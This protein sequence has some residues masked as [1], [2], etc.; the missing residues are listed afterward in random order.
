MQLVPRALIACRRAGA[1]SLNHCF[2]TGSSPTSVYAYCQRGSPMCST[3]S[4]KKSVK[5]DAMNDHVQLLSWNHTCD[6]T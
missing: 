5:L 3:T 1:S 4:R 2:A 6:S